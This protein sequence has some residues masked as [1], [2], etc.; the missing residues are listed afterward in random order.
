MQM[1]PCFAAPHTIATYVVTAVGAGADDADHELSTSCGP[2]SACR[3]ADDCVCEPGLPDA[4]APPAPAAGQSPLPR[5]NDL[6]DVVTLSVMPRHACA[7]VCAAVA[8][9]DACESSSQGLQTHQLQCFA[10]HGALRTSSATA[11]PHLLVLHGFVGHALGKGPDIPSNLAGVL[12]C[13][14]AHVACHLPYGKARLLWFE[15]VSS[16]ICNYTE[17]WRTLV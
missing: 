7:V 2:S 1:L 12:C 5:L 6:K 3:P 17:W 4:A 11:Q 13:H 15:H 9:C 16:C 14:C 10:G 8:T